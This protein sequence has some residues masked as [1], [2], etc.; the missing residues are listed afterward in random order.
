[1]RLKECILR[2]DNQNTEKKNLHYLLDY[3]KEAKIAK[4]F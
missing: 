1:M 2:G 3:I 4:F